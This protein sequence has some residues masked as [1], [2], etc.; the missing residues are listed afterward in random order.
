M[1]ASELKAFLNGDK[2]LF[3]DQNAL[4]S[5]P[6]HVKLRLDKGDIESV[7][8]AIN[9]L[10]E[11]LLSE[12]AAIQPDIAQAAS[13]IGEF[14]LD[15]RQMALLRQ[16]SHRAMVWIILE[17]QPTPPYKRICNLLRELAA[18][19]ILEGL[20]EESA[21]ILETFY[22][23][24]AGKLKKPREIRNLAA[25]LL[26]AAATDEVLD[27]LLDE[28]QTNA[29]S[30][31]SS[32]IDCLLHLGTASAGPLLGLLRWSPSRYERARI[33]QMLSFIGRQA[34]PA[35][36]REIEKDHPWFFV[37]NVVQLLGNLGDSR[38]AS[39][40]EPL[41]NHKDIRV[42]REAIQAIH[43]MSGNKSEAIALSILNKADDRLKPDIVRVLGSVKSQKAIPELLR[44]LRSDVVNEVEDLGAAICEALGAIGSPEAIPDLNRIIDDTKI[45]SFQ[46][47][48]AEALA[49]IQ[50]KTGRSKAVALAPWREHQKIWMD[51]YN[52]M[53]PEEGDAFFSTLI[54]MEYEQDLPLFQQG[55]VNRR[56]YFIENGELVLAYDQDGEE[57][58]VKT[59]KP[60]DIAGEESFFSASVTTTSLRTI[61]RAQVR[62]LEK[63]DFLDRIEDFPGLKEKIKQYCYNTGNIRA[64]LKQYGMERR[65]DQRAEV[66]AKVSAQFLDKDDNPLK[67]T[68]RG[69]LLDISAGGISFLAPL[70][71]E[72]ACR[73][74]GRRINTKLLLDVCDPP[75]EIDQNGVIV[76][77][78]PKNNQASASIHVKFDWRLTR[79]LDMDS[80]AKLKAVSGHFED[81]DDSNKKDEFLITRMP[82]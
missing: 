60:G 49:G 62:I 33:L 72:K 81:D 4:N 15:R 78:F 37:R 74:V 12:D 51:M 38:H 58:W 77:V 67:K 7:E 42:Q 43:R 53:S 54:R 59:L 44:L 65:I 19:L 68:I 47:V 25:E 13:R 50:E 31:R 16:L 14:L 28:F 36:I 20:F 5:L 71:S 24:R 22:I 3:N 61:T 2:R 76:A 55:E 69:D 48:A 73:F 1:P 80:F 45:A 17:T 35:L 70:A 29:R 57:I 9:R 46:S 26:D 32:A 8:M 27:I 66:A 30:K 63:D 34:V 6:D 21:H 82:E 79:L 23:I 64:I 75:L 52:T 18:H 41:L 10:G 56:L 39:L 40:L 11:G